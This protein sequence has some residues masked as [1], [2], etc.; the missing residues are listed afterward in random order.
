MS[1]GSRRR[2]QTQPPADRSFIGKI[3]PRK[4]FINDRHAGMILIVLCRKIA[5][6]DD[7]AA[8][9]AKVIRT[10][11]IE[12]GAGRLLALRPALNRKGVRPICFQWMVVAN[13]G[14]LHPWQ[15]GKL[16]DQFLVKTIDAGVVVVL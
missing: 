14:G 13:R 5:T 10:Y 12:T 9:R 16:F 1:P 11:G 6:L 7:S 3:S 8:E 4:C 2:A 15:S